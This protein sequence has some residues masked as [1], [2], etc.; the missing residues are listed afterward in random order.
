MTTILWW[1]LVQLFGLAA[2]PLAFRLCSRLPDR[3]YTLARPLGLL[4][5]GYLLWLGGS[6][7]F[8]KNGIGAVVVVLVL[9]GG[10]SWWLYATRLKQN[11]VSLSAWA[12]THVIYVVCVEALFGLALLGWTIFKAHNPDI[13]TTGGEKWME[14]AFVNATLRSEHFPPQ[15]P[16]LSGYG[17]SYYYFGYVLMAMVTR[18]SGLPATVAYNLF[19]PTLFALTLSGA[20]GL[21]Y[22]L[23]TI[24]RQEDEY[25]RSGPVQMWMRLLYG[26]LGVIFVGVIGNLEGFLEVLHSRGLLPIGFWQWL[27]IKDINVAPPLEGSW[28]PT[29]FMW[30]WRASRV[31]HDC[32]LQGLATGNCNP[33]GGD[34]EVI[35]EFPF[36]SFLL[37]DVHPHVL[38]LPFVLLGLGL[39][40]NTFVGAA[41]IH[42][43]AGVK[44]SESLSEIGTGPGAGA[45]APATPMQ[46][47]VHLVK[48][49]FG[50][51]P[52]F[53]LAAVCLG[54]L[55]F[56]NTWDFPIY[57]AVMSVAI[58][59]ARAQLGRTN[60]ASEALIIGG[61]LGLLG[62][63]LYAPFYVGFRSQ[64]S[65]VL[66]NLF[67]PTKVQQF[68]VFFG[69]FLFVIVSYLILISSR[70]GWR[71]YWKRLLPLLLATVMAPVIAMV[72]MVMV[73]GVSPALRPH[74]DGIL[75]D[76][77]MQSLI[78]QP[79]TWSLVSL[80]LRLHLSNPLTWL[81]LSGL[82]IWIALIWPSHRSLNY[83]SMSSALLSFSD[84]FVLLLTGA[85]ILLPL[86][87]EFVYLRDNFGIRMNTVFKFYYQAWILFAISAAYGVWA[88]HAHFIR[89]GALAR[90]KGHGTPWQPILGGL[91][92]LVLVC[93]VLAG[94]IYPVLSIL[95]KV[96]QH[97]GEPHL[98]G[99]EWL[100]RVHPGDYAAIRWLQANVYGEAVILETPGDRYAA[101]DY[102]G[103]V[104]A[105]T[106]LATL[107]GWGNHEHQWRGSY[108]VPARREPDIEMLFNGLD[109]SRTMT[110]LDQYNITYV[111]VGELERK[112][113]HANGLAKFE[114]LMEPVYR[115]GDV[116][117]YQRR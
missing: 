92:G 70:Q 36:F 114:Q 52:E 5:A 43:N 2:L 30:W 64:A 87:V 101:Y 80:A 41:R 83:H 50:G 39:I 71:F 31:I 72:T 109:T 34:W 23:V 105:L 69:P 96:A 15:D 47:L 97:R 55:G 57:L 115:Q 110:L 51:W 111:Y 53:V 49:V 13:E 75:H 3:G 16:W 7:G 79:A 99:M 21:V 81:L 60:W 20:F 91:W 44:A 37:G 98:D 11:D 59:A 62:V 42:E 65:G 1:I 45:K 12:R 66:P 14:I 27:D 68:F 117:I 67:N 113:Y 89:F 46:S 112:R 84:R 22:N 54:G 108:E 40:L 18:L 8:W 100:S 107:L 4:L 93:L 6:L 17:I 38:A 19:V 94:L 58:A 28:I 104:S 82:L 74:I 33:P 103:R 24:G 61:G 85:G 63:G 25:E 29:R 106:G 88:L 73:A 35:D 48:S 95:D 76:P 77:H 9:I 86:I 90:S 32:S 26:L 56:L 78:G 10:V 102:V 116:V